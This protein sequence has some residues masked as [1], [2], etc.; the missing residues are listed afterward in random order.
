MFATT[1]SAMLRMPIYD[2]QCG[3]KLF[4]V[5]AA[6]RAA[7]AEPFLSKWVFDVELL[8]RYLKFFDRDPEKLAQVIYEYP[9]NEWVDV[10][11][12]KVRP[13]DFLK[14]FLDVIRIRRRYL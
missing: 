1:V 3:A 10:A 8:A 12:S 14:A 7:F 11:G 2:T 9:L 5:N 13:S 4:R 6:T